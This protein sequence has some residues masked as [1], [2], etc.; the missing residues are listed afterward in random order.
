MQLTVTSDLGDEIDFECADTWVSK[1][2]CE[3]IL[4]GKTYPALPFVDD[5]QVVWD[6]G[7]NCGATTVHLARHYPNAVVH[8]F[9]PATEP[10]AFLER[11]TAGL[12]NVQ[13]HPIGLHDHDDVVPLYKGDEDSI[14]G[15][16][17]RRNVN[18]DESEPVE[19]RA[20]GRWATEHGVDRIDVLKLDVEGCE[21]EVLE[22]LSGLLKTVKVLYVEYDSRQA[23]RR[24]DDLLRDTHEL[25]FGML[26]ALDQGDVIYLSAELADLPVATEHLRVLFTT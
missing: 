12:H 3:P 11:N 17:I 16:V 19:L 21:A 10:R 9:E 26:T 14:T 2:V 7:A 13:V 5:V 20:A 1:W 23:R 18:L 25:Y 22:S 8:A 24:I 15:S 6:A 4:Q